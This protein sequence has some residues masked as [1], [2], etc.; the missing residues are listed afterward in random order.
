MKKSTTLDC[1]VGGIKDG[2][3]LL[4][5]Y[6]D[7]RLIYVGRVGSGLSG[8][9]KELILSLTRE[10][11]NSPFFGYESRRSEKIKWVEPNGV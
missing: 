2:N 8:K 9:V 5:L 4:G 10:R 11:E 6:D 7:D 1:V 3:L